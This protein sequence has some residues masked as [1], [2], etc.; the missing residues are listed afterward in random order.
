LREGL[1][2]ICTEWCETLSNLISLRRFGKGKKQAG[3]N[4]LQEVFMSDYSDYESKKLSEEAKRYIS[5]LEKDIV[6]CYGCQPR[7][8]EN[9]DERIWSWG[10]RY[11]MEDYLRKKN[12][13]YEY[14]DEIIDN[15]ICPQCG[16]TYINGVG[17]SEESGF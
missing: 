2:R 17:I 11:E 13:P 3:K 15:M 1:I 6:A 16:G 8:D 5:E 7:D 10:V 14:W 4:I 12:I 9:R